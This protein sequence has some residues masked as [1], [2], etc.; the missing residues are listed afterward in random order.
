[1]NKK[2][3]RIFILFVV[4]GTVTAFAGAPQGRT[5]RLNKVNGV[6]SATLL[7]INNISAWYSDNGEGERNPNTGNSGLTFPRGTSTA[8]YASGLMIGAY[9][10][11]GVSALPRV[12][13][14]SYNSGFAPGA[15]L[16]LRTGIVESAADPNVRIWRIRK[17][18]ATAD[19]KQD[20]AETYSKP[21]AAVTE[22]DISA[23][24]VQYRKDWAEW[25]AS[26]GAPF[27]DANNDGVYTP[28]FETVSGKE[29]PK[30]YPQADEP[31]LANADQ[32]IW[33]VSNDIANGDS[34][35]KTKP[36]GLEQQVTLWGYNVGG[37]NGNTLYKKY[38]LIYKGTSQT[39]VGSQLQNVYITHWSDP[40][41]GDPGD[42]YVGCDTVLSL[43]YVYNAYATDKEYS[44]FNVVPPAL[45]YDFLQGPLVSS[46]GDTAVFD[47]KKRAGFKNL[48]MTAFTYFAAGGF[49]SDPPF[50][51][52]GSTQ[53][54]QLMRGLPP[55]PQGP[56]DPSPVIDPVLK[57]PSKFW[58]SGDPISKEGWIDGVLEGPGD[59]RMLQSSGPF[60]MVLGDTQ[61][62]VVGVIGAVG[63]DYLNSVTALKESDRY[64]QFTYNGLFQSL[65]PT[66][67]ASVTYPNATEAAVKITA[68]AAAGSITS[69]TCSFNNSQVQLFDDGTHGD[70]SAADGVF[71]NSVTVSRTAAP[72]GIDITF[73]NT[74]SQTST[75]KNVI[76]RVTTAGTLVVS[77]AQV[78]FDNIN[79]NGVVNNGEFVHYR[80]TVKNNSPFDATNVNAFV[81]S[82]TS[83]A[84]DYQFGTIAANGESTV[85]SSVYFTF[86]LPK[87]YSNPTYPVYVSMRDDKGNSWD[88]S[89]D[90]P[91]VQFASIADSLTTLA[92][93]TAGNN[94][95]QVGVVVFDPAAAG[96]VYDIWYGAVGPTIDWTIVKNL[97]GTDYATV[98][99]NLSA[100]KEVPAI[101]TLPN[102]Q[103]TGTFTINDAH[104]QVAY[105]I[106]VS[107][108]TGAITDAGI[109]FG[110]Y[111][112]SG[113]LVKTLSFS[114]NTA[115]G[116][117]S[118]SDVSQSFADSLFKYFVAGNLYVNIK[119]A[120]NPNG[121]VRGQIAD[122]MNVRQTIDPLIAVSQP[123]YSYTENRFAGFSLYVGK[124]KLGSKGV[125]QTAPTVG[126]VINTVNP[127][128]TYR[129]V[130][131]LHLLFAGTKANE[132]K[133][134]LKFVNGLNWA[135][136]VPPVANP[137]P[138]QSY[139]I[140]VPFA[141]FK[142]TVRVVPT[143][144]DMNNDSVWNTTSNPKYAG[145]SVFDNIK[146]VADTRDAVNNDL[147]YYSSANTVF[148]PTTVAVKGRYMNA[149]N[150]IL[151]NIL[152][153]SESGVNTAPAAG[154]VITFTQYQ[155]VKP[156]DIKTVVLK[157][158]GVKME[159]ISMIPEAFSLSQ[160][161]PNPFNPSTRIEFGL[162]VQSGVTLKVY[163]IIGREVA[164]LFSGHR[165][166]GRFTVEWNGK[167]QFNSSVASGIYFYRLEAGSFIQTKKMIL[168]K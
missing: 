89:W 68:T 144:V 71:A 126:S 2:L 27:Y 19:L 128:N 109:Y 69:I 51:L 157:T 13:G 11:D 139:F 37:L 156:G 75:I 9:S 117:W 90:F 56:P 168:L 125:Q 38:K 136:A 158:L 70:G 23:L 142:D 52:N 122:G 20:A 121:E 80:L 18:Y 166:A 60:T 108:L 24:T 127:E 115:S 21:A 163:D 49:Y 26:K 10:T 162:P 85:S 105:S 133:V 44:K 146:G 111:N 96:Q 78:V 65:P 155:S 152:V 124:A 113:P 12:T 134:E 141:A 7:N 151:S 160:N 92:V 153:T 54:Y 107:G 131:T 138:S 164:T 74:K 73:T 154:T 118:K 17:D 103:G 102:A 30:H 83:A 143:V 16:G 159:Q 50:N 36:M 25:P 47:L 135:V 79:N 100:K 129:L 161:Y 112:L 106:T 61:E 167:D 35:W 32:V 84:K 34:P 98:S 46:P 150:H 77:A 110:T 114:G 4:L 165:N 148:P 53:W 137:T 140:K 5:P 88:T 147:S 33:Y 91:V 43:G 99:A 64:V 97:A 95:G 86:R 31:G 8:I 28:Q 14:H 130:D 81:T 101:T 59:R 57:A 6:P 48:P 55:T 1:M 76:E 94:D 82:S 45:G 123:I 104:T 119:T 149:A 58:L 39:P 63:K 93:N 3:F 120:A 116:I 41:L 66:V 145:K 40:D 29:V 15:I 42:D 67:T 87:T 62:I 132:A 22:A 72:T